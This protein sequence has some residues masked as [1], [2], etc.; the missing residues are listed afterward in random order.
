MGSGE[1]EEGRDECTEE[2]YPKRG[3]AQRK[4]RGRGRAPSNK[5]RCWCEPSFLITLKSS[6]NLRCARTIFSESPS[7]ELLHVS[8]SRTLHILRYPRRPSSPRRSR[9]SVALCA[10]SAAWRRSGSRFVHVAPQRIVGTAATARLRVG[11]TVVSSAENRQLVKC[12]PRHQA[13]SAHNCPHSSASAL[14]MFSALPKHGTPPSLLGDPFH[15]TAS[16]IPS[17]VF[18]SCS[19][20]TQVSAQGHISLSPS[21]FFSLDVFFSASPQDHSHIAAHTTCS[22]P[23]EDSREQK[24]NSKHPFRGYRR[25]H[26][27]VLR[28]PH[29]HC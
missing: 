16:H 20:Y 3:R 18:S 2:R 26:R 21:T 17:A 12:I 27:P 14:C 22:N 8:P 25:R 24:F 10:D 19:A 28:L 5:R 15:L 9:G 4:N 29:V 23:E 11:P 6:L 1:E 7:A 13:P